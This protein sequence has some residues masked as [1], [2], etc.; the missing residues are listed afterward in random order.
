M[1]TCYEVTWL[2]PNGDW[3][4]TRYRGLSFQ[5]TC[6]TALPRVGDATKELIRIEKISENQERN[7]KA[8]FAAGAAVAR[9]VKARPPRRSTLDDRSGLEELRE[10]ATKVGFADHPYYTYFL[11][12]YGSEQK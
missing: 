10:R 8:A 4:Y 6:R 1:S 5:E 2:L 9:E 12:G 11:R 3:E 7:I